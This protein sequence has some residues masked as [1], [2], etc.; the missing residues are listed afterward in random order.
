[1]NLKNFNN[2]SEKNLAHLTKFQ[3]DKKKFKEGVKNRDQLNI[4]FKILLI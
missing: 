1:M 4:I 2:D 3:F